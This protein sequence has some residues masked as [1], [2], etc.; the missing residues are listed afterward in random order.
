[1][2]PCEDPAFAPTATDPFRGL[3]RVSC[4]INSIRDYRELLTSLLA[5]TKE[6]MDCE[7]GSLMLYNEDTH[8]LSW[9]VA[10][11]EKADKLKEMGRLPMG[12]GVAGWVAENRKPALVPDT[13]ADERFFRGTDTRTGFQTRSIL[14][15]PLELGGKL[16]GV[17]Q[18]LNPKNKKGFDERDLEIFEAYGSMAATAIEK[19]RWQEAMVEQEGLKRDLEAAR[20]IQA[21]FLPQSLD[22][23]ADG[24]QIAFAYQPAQQVGGDFYDAKRNVGGA[25]AF[26][27]GDVTGKG[28][29]A[30]LLTAQILSE[31]RHQAPQC[32][33]PSIILARVNDA[34]AARSA[35]GMFATAWCG[36]A[37]AA[38]GG[39]EVVH[40]CAGHPAPLRAGNGQAAFVE[41][42]SG[43][44]IGIA[45]GMEYPSSRLALASGELVCLY[46]D[47][48]IEGRDPA[49]NEYGYER[50]RRLAEG[51]PVG[52][53]AAAEAIV[54]DAK[55]FWNGA[56]QR[57]DITLLLFGS[58]RP[59]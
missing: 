40:A 23:F 37:R 7:A 34:L 22:D 4:I 50:L 59:S 9:H 14:C 1:M 46:T 5:T 8:D 57:D 11:G 15:V 44:P 18:A 49:G 47:G 2:K 56:P 20:E 30:A 54:A 29:P 10:L 42:R 3:V 52:A 53:K 45:P 17:L 12:K 32:A 55:G 48:I 43:P 28:M 13:A 58:R 51:W 38:G 31:F 6:V 39:I 21:R 41:T 35:R 25:V 36:V 33:D 26:F 27:F 16:V 19:I 24:L